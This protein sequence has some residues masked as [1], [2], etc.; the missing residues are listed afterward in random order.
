[1]QGLHIH[2]LD[3]AHGLLEH[4]ADIRFSVRTSYQWQPSGTGKRGQIYFSQVALPRSPHHVLQ[5]GQ[6]HQVV[7]AQDANYLSSLDTLKAW[8]DHDGVKVL[9]CYLMIMF[10]SSWSQTTTLITSPFSTMI[11]DA[12]VS[13]VYPEACGCTPV[14][15]QDTRGTEQR[16]NIMAELTL[17]RHTSTPC[18]RWSKAPCVT[19]K[20]RV[21][22]GFSVIDGN[23]T[24]FLPPLRGGKKQVS[25]N[26]AS[27]LRHHDDRA[28]LPEMVIKSEILLD[29]QPCHHDPAD[30][31]RETPGLI[32]VAL[33]DTPDLL[34][35]AG[36]RSCHLGNLLSKQTGSYT[37]GT[38]KLPAHFHQGEEFIYYI[39]RGH[40]RLSIRL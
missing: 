14:M 11:L 1:M 37:E 29:P 31:I 38:L 16:G 24:G 18:S 26:P 10:I 13:A 5:R 39:I 17:I 7:L 34:D 36:L 23:P 40:Q 6:N 35:I 19:K 22:V 21:G 32:V 8:K 12:V 15:H 2:L 20:I 33:K 30:T 27:W 4:M 28:K 9:A 3:A 25:S